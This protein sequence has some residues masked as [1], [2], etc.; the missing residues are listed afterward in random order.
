ME[1]D[2]SWKRINVDGGITISGDMRRVT[3]DDNLT[4]IFLK[5]GMSS[6]EFISTTPFK[7]KVNRMCDTDGQGTRT[8]GLKIEIYP[9]GPMKLAF[10]FSDP[11]KLFVYDVK[12]KS[13]LNSDVGQCITIELNHN[14]IVSLKNSG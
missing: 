8:L 4:N 2:I 10:D 6:V 11:T 5:Y 7:C 13:Q 12:G 9:D 14:Y 3:S 1:S